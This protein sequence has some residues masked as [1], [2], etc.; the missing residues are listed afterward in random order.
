[1]LLHGVESIG[2][3][4][5]DGCQNLLQ[6]TI[7]SSI[8]NIGQNA[9]SST[10]ALGAV[11]AESVEAWCKIQFD[12]ESANPLSSAR[13]LYVGGR[14]LTELIIPN[15]IG[16]LSQNAFSGCCDLAYAVIPESV[17]SVGTCAFRNC[18]NL[19]WV[20]LQGNSPA[21]EDDIYSGTPDDLT[22]YVQEGSTG[23]LFMGSA[24]LPDKWPQNDGSSR[25]IAH[26][27][28][29]AANP[30]RSLTFKG[31]LESRSFKGSFKVYAVNGARAKATTVSVTGVM[32]EGVGYGTA[33]VKGEGSARA[34]IE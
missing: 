25:A 21:V 9:F 1:M 18:S 13:H 6:I 2:S 34:T 30:P 12:G 28:Y 26:G 8:T 22:T 31:N 33:A 32:V 20:W 11:H 23:W 5:F 29:D 10:S 19:K 24:A 14:L 15:E 7:P 17:I 3:Y 27:A 4:A 16:H